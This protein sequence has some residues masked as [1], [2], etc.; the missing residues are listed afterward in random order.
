MS[1]KPLV[2][3]KNPKGRGKGMG[4]ADKAAKA[5]KAPRKTRICSRLSK[6]RLTILI[7]EVDS[8]AKGFKG[9]KGLKGLKGLKRFKGGGTEDDYYK[10]LEGLFSEENM[11]NIKR[12]KEDLVNDI[13]GTMAKGLENLV[14]FKTDTGVNETKKR[15]LLKFISIINDIDNLEQEHIDC[16]ISNDSLIALPY[17]EKITTLVTINMFKKVY[18]LKYQDR[19]IQEPSFKYLAN[20]KPLIKKITDVY[21]GVNNDVGALQGLTKDVNRELEYYNYI[22]ILNDYDAT[23]GDENDAIKI[24]EWMKEKCKEIE[25][26]EFKR[27]INS[28]NINSNNFSTGCDDNNLKDAITNYNETIEKMKGM[29]EFTTLIIEELNNNSLYLLLLSNNRDT[30]GLLSLP[31]RKKS[32]YDLYNHITTYENEFKDIKEKY[33]RCVKPFFDG[34]LL[35]KYELKKEL[36]PEKK[37]ELGKFL[38]KN[39]IN[40]LG[41]EITRIRQTRYSI[42]IKQGN[43]TGK[44]YN[45]IP[46]DMT[47]IIGLFN[48]LCSAN[49]TYN[50]HMD[51]NNIKEER[52]KVTAAEKEE[53]VKGE[54]VSKTI[55]N[56]NGIKEAAAKEAARERFKKAINMTKDKNNKAKKIKKEV[57]DIIGV[58]KTNVAVNVAN[59][60]IKPSLELSLQERNEKYESPVYNNEYSRMTP[61]QNNEWR[62]GVDNTSVQDTPENRERLRIE[63][64]ATK[65]RELELTERLQI[66]ADN[67]SKNPPLTQEQI[68]GNAKYKGDGGKLTTKYISTGDFVYILY[69]KKK[70][71]RCVYTKAKGRGKY[72][73]IKGDYIL[74]SKLKVV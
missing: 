34:T 70:I 6:G 72:C 28:T 41:Y 44:F 4:N 74:V 45:D 26:D 51:A 11:K 65:Q 59:A 7:A 2:P 46:F 19:Q 69:E 49:T 61:H 73:K 5:T 52:Y 53:V 16:I 20:T 54:V 42:E 17:I 38:E 22:Y 15:H 13:L 14:D 67:W 43:N 23:K 27:F 24:I 9:F 68:T 58:L 31:D 47:E 60:S 8:I 40:N 63:N 66:D 18:N 39:E 3:N 71:K 50:Q 48:I 30:K 33:I 21:N 36:T 62:F 29:N 56:V 10:R 1:K 55:I 35:D 64:E 12:L 57:Q 37:I 25:K 32:L